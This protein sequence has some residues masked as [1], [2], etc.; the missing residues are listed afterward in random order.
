M[1]HTIIPR[2]T[3]TVHEAIEEAVYNF[4]LYHSLGLKIN[5]K[6]YRLYAAKTNGARCKEY[7]S[8]DNNQELS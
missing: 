8:L 3:N 1:I 5:L 2:G 4:N 7:P 6:A